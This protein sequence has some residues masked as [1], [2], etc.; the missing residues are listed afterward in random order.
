MTKNLLAALLTLTTSAALAQTAETPAAGATP[1]AESAP[2]QSAESSAAQPTE[3]PAAPSV[4]DRLTTTE[5]KVA[6]IEEQNIET[7]TDLSALKKLQ[8]SGYVQARFGAQQSLDDS[9]AGGFNRFYI[10]RSRLKATYTGDVAQ[11]MFQIDATTSSVS[12]KDVEATLFI[13][14][15]KQRLSLTVGQTKWPFGYEAPQSSSEREF[16]E[17]SLVVRSFLPG[18]RDVGAK[19]NGRWGVFRL[20]V[21]I[22][23]GNGI[24]NTNFIGTDNDK[25]K[26]VVGRAGF[27]LGWLSG[28]VSG[29]RGLTLGKRTGSTPDAF[30]TAYARNRIG[31]DAQVYL[32]LI[33]LGGTAIKAEYIAGKS[34]Q[35]SG[36][37]IYGTPAGGWWAM[38]VQNIGLSD[39]LAVR[40]DHFDFENGRKAVEADGKLGSNNAVGTLGATAIH[41]FGENLK[42]SATYELLSTATADSG[43]VEDP[44]DNLFTLQFQARF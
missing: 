28:G 40:Y 32:D 4:D 24:Q 21:G 13:P 31:A 36:N 25:E 11:Y 39:A 15:T 44:K 42:V 30:R 16:P 22:F 8:F 12:L 38:V 41:Y 14:G 29:W 43:S 3:T 20:N 5:G 9:G 34:Y 2:A 19:F 26:D 23:N 17:R 6:A 27:D 1:P 10:R 18:E 33:P 37:E 35:R 7:K